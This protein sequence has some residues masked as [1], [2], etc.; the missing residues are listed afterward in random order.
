VVEIADAVLVNKADGQGLPAARRARSEFERVLHYLRPATEGWTTGAFDCS[1]VTGEGVM[2]MWA[3]VEKFAALTRGSGVFDRRR[4]Q[5][6]Q[7]WV[8]ALVR[9]GLEDLF[10]SHP[11]VSTRMAA[12]EQQVARGELPAT[13]AARR[14]L[15][16]FRAG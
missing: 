1:S 11:G 15:D 6:E 3:V 13:V 9:E 12:L 2:E 14:L 5:Q 16:L 4:S 10:H 8:R 7:E